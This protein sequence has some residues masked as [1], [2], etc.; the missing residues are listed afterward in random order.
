MS[1]AARAVTEATLAGDFRD[2]PARWLA[3]L[4]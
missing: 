4:H 2:A 3:H 1:L